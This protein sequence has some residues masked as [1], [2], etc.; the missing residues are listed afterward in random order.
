MA[1]WAGIENNVIFVFQKTLDSNPPEP[2]LTIFKNF[3]VRVNSGMD[4]AKAIKY[5][6]S[7]IHSPFMRHVFLNIVSVIENNGDLRIL[8]NKF[9]Y[10]SFKIEET[11]WS[12]QIRLYKDRILLHI[13][14]LMVLVTLIRLFMAGQERMWMSGCS[15]ISM[16]IGV[17]VA[18]RIKRPKY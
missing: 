12:N 8:L 7:R 13:L 6:L 18:Y 11:L 4:A 14:N 10:E 16:V 1:R 5:E 9:E 2:Y 17:I 15:I 3:I